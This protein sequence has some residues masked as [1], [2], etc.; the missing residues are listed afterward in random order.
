MNL[1]FD[2]S[3]EVFYTGQRR[4]LDWYSL[5]PQQV[6]WKRVLHG[7]NF[8]LVFGFF[9][10][11]FNLILALYIGIN[12]RQMI[13]VMKGFFVLAT[14]VAYSIKLFSFKSNNVA[15]L[16]F[17]ANLH[18]ALFRPASP[19][20]QQ[21]FVTARE[22]SRTIRNSYGAVSFCT[23]SILLLTQYVIDNTELPL[24]T[25]D[26]FNGTPGSFGYCVMYIYQCVALSF[27]CFMNISIDSLCCSTF[28][29][30][31]CQL[32]ILALRLQ[33]IGTDCDLEDKKKGAA[34][35]VE[36][37]LRKCIQYHMKIV[38]LAADIEALVYKP[39]SAQIFCSVLVLTANFYAMS[40]LSDEKLLFLK[41]LIY[42]VCMLL[43]I[44]ILCYFAGEITQRSLGL[45][46]DLYR[47]NWVGWQRS[48]RRLLLMLM[49]RLDIPIRIR[50]IN[51]SHAFDLE[52]FGSYQV[53]YFD[54]L[55]MWRLHLAA[56]W[57]QNVWH[58]LRC[59]L[60]LGIV[61][62]MLLFF[63]IR[64]LDNIDQLSVILQVFFMFATELSCMTK[65]LSIKLQNEQH[66]R[67]IDEMHSSY[68]RPRSAKQTLIYRRGAQRSVKW[69]NLYAWSS[70]L[71]ASLILVTQWFV[72][73]NALPLSMYEPCNLARPS[74]YYGLYLY[75]VMSLMPTCW[76]NIAFD[77]ISGSFLFFLETQLA[78]LAA[79]LESLGAVLTPLDDQRIALELRDCC[80]HYARI[81][82]LKDLVDGFIKVPGSVQMLCSVLVLVSNFYAISIRTKE[83]AFMIMMVSY[84][85]VMLLQIFIICYGAEEMSHQS[86]LLAHALYSSDWTSWSRS[87]RK[88][89]LLMMLRFNAPLQMHTLNHSQSFNST[90]FAS[91]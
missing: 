70:V 18:D 16:Q 57:Q 30:I 1:T 17:F 44:F 60:M 24:A 21:I 54:M 64:V 74:C 81:V 5:W 11:I 61:S 32:D 77:S 12:I 40:Q 68:F 52:L 9:M 10:M 13:E 62:V 89:G 47:S 41:M 7:M 72:D 27:G 14:S 35:E 25:Y 91:V 88:M 55:G 42:Q 56:T 38:Q 86:T 66:A 31:R 65:L 3:V 75:Q 48:N 33:N 26:P 51:G 79:R 80:I 34:A 28:I 45:P 90:T 87:N 39:I 15:L 73:N 69:R 83:T 46:H 22:L 71:A 82:Q 19:E 50:T 6:R 29:F 59:C 49:Q 37:Q 36:L 23:L 4:I 20:E 76:I 8:W 58:Q 78:M 84:Q 63:A 43:Q 85:L 67:L 2:R 53:W